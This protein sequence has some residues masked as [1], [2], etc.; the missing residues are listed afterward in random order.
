MVQ[1]GMHGG[2]EQKKSPVRQADDR[3]EMISNANQSSLDFYRQGNSKL[4]K[5]FNHG[6]NMI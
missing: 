4:L 5:E 6:S 1:I 2:K 3:L